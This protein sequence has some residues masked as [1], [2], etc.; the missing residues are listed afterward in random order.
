MNL[1][2]YFEKE[3]GPFAHL[4]GLPIDEAQ[5]IQSDL[6]K[7]GKVFAAKRNP[8]YLTRRRYL[9]QLTRKLFIEKGG[10]PI[11]ETPYYMVVEECPWLNT[12]YKDAGYIRIPISEFDLKTISFTYGD[13]FPTFSPKV[14]DNWEFRR[15]VYN[16]DEI[17]KVI[18]KYGLPQNDWKEPIFAQ[19]A[20]VEV[21]IWSDEPIAQYRLFRM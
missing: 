14:T 10:L 15:T 6:Q 3:K 16:Y 17:L 8:E 7:E 18:A 1:Y 13:T 11:R 4:S 9:E 20:Y 21:Q 2:H 19:P 12:W 5:R